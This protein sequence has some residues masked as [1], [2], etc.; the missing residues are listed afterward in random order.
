RGL[1]EWW[2][3]AH[4]GARVHACG[5]IPMNTAWTCGAVAASRLAGAGNGSAPARSAG[6]GGGSHGA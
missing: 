6:V 5:M 3:V 1:W 4:G 2:R